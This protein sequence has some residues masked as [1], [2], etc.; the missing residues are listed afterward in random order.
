MGDYR[1]MTHD[2]TIARWLAL[3][4]YS[5]TTHC[6]TSVSSWCGYCSHKMQLEESLCYPKEVADCDE[7]RAI[8][9]SGAASALLQQFLT[10]VYSAT[11]L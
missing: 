10:A 7:A 6:L 3:T 8:G 5:T 11:V 1:T 4:H 9:I 2:L